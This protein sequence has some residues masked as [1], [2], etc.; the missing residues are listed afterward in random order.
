MF[1]TILKF[2][3]RLAAFLKSDRMTSP[4]WKR[5]SSAWLNNDD[6]DGCEWFM[7]RS[8][9]EAFDS[10]CAARRHGSGCDGVAGNDCGCR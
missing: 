6:K 2:N 1:Q 7:L 10:R 4:Q 9:G 3:E 8:V 5:S